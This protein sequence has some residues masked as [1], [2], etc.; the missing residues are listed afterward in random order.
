[1]H[2]LYPSGVSE[3]KIDR[4]AWAKVLLELL[5]AETRGKI[6]PFAR[7]VSVDPRTV[8]HWLDQTVDVSEESVRKVAQGTKRSPMD[9]LVKV[10]YYSSTD[11]S[12]APD[13]LDAE[14]DLVRTDDRLSPEV[15]KRVLDH[16]TERRQRDLEDTRRMIELL[17]GTD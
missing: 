6:A 7:K 17:R 10:G 16:I 2:A 12:P 8:R 11:V 9:L 3:R 15:K 14:I 13:T 4:A 1:M 5:H